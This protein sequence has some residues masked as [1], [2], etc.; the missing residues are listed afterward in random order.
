MIENNPKEKLSQFP[1]RDIEFAD[2]ETAKRY[3]QWL[4]ENQD[5]INILAKQSRED[6]F[7]EAAIAHFLS[8]EAWQVADGAT[9]QRERVLERNMSHAIHNWEA[10]A[11]RVVAYGV[12]AR[13]HLKKN[14]ELSKGLKQG[15][16]VAAKKRTD[17]GVKSNEELSKDVIDWYDGNRKRGRFLTNNQVLSAVYDRG[18]GNKYELSTLKSKVNIILAS[19]RKKLKN[20]N[21]GE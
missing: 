15:P 19:H 2:S 3:N 18:W 9:T 13:E 14:E 11:F 21:T 4:N 20:N 1:L 6:L 8:Y 12:T 10:A 16:K 5:L 7:R 17:K